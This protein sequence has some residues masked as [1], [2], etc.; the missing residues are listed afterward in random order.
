[1]P[2]VLLRTGHLDSSLVQPLYKSTRLML[3]LTLRRLEYVVLRWLCTVVSA[4][5]VLFTR[6]SRLAS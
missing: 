2:A 6:L 4:D 1:M 3:D 5:E